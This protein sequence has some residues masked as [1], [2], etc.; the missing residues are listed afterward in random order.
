MGRQLDADLAI[1]RAEVADADA[2]QHA[3]RSEVSGPIRSDPIRCTGAVVASAP[4]R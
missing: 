3:L 2:A 4:R 1:A